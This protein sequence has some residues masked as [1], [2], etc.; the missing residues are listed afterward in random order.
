MHDLPRTCEVDDPEELAGY[1]IV[2]RSRGACPPVLALVE[3]LETENLQGMIRGKRRSDRI[4]ARCRFAPARTLEKVHVVGSALLQPVG[5]VDMQQQTAGVADD[6]QALRVLGHRV[7][8]LRQHVCQ[9]TEG[10]LHPSLPDL[11]RV[12]FDRGRP[13][14]RVES[15]VERTPPR[16]DDR[17]PQP[18]GQLRARLGLQ[19]ATGK[20]TLPALTKPSSA[21]ARV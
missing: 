18:P 9:R 13:A 21:Y 7:Q 5:A 10:M 16:L 20:Q 12:G 14:G 1:R 8:L 19:V 2:D 11:R 15:G 17:L 4:R 3:V 6:D